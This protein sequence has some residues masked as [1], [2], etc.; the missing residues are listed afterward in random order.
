MK[1]VIIQQVKST[2]HRSKRQKLT[3]E[4]LGLGKINR[5]KEVE[6]SPSIVGMINKVNHLINVKEL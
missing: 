1:K 4:A 2:I 3:I 6:L 5:T